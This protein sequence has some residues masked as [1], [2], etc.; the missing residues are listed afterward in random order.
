[1]IDPVAYCNRRQQRCS[2]SVLLSSILPHF[3]FFSY[4]LFSRIFVFAACVAAHAH[5]GTGTVL[6]AE[7]GRSEA[8]AL[9]APHP[10]RA[11]PKI[12]PGVSVNFV[13]S[14]ADDGVFEKEIRAKNNIC[15]VEG[16]GGLL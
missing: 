1:M 7:Q 16:G 3:F 13:T 9:L 4:F 14:S 15:A 8:I 11:G 6:A 12:R 2:T 5:A 10:L